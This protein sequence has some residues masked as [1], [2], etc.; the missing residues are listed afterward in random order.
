M[1]ELKP[2]IL[3]TC[4]LRLHQFKY[5]SKTGV[6]PVDELYLMCYNTGDVKKLNENNSIFNYANAKP[7]FENVQPYPKKLNFALPAFSWAIIFKNN[8]FYKIDNSLD[9]SIFTDKTI[10]KKQGKNNLYQM[11]I[12][13]VINDK[14][15]RK[16]DLI[17]VENI[18]E[19]AMLQ[20]ANLC[21]KAVNSND[22]KV[23]FYDISH[24]NK[25]NYE[26]VHKAFSDFSF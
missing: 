9:E 3:L 19:E 21:S 5:P 22:F 20:A 4:T 18:S 2:Q 1:K 11:Q 10:T 25:S 17:R 8:Q 16:G 24:I 15:L 14:F 12:D 6:P 13:T 23:V 7:Y 26:M